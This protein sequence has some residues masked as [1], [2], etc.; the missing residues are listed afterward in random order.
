MPLKPAH[1]RLL[2]RVRRSLREFGELLAFLWAGASAVGRVLIG[3]WPQPATVTDIGSP[4]PISPLEKAAG[5][6]DRL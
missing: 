6:S 5:G 2:V 3:R 1:L 4:E